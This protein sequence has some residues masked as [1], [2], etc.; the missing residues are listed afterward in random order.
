[1]TDKVA[2]SVAELAKMLGISL[3][4]AYELANSAGFPSIKIGKRTLI[5]LVPF[6]VW[7]NKA[8]EPTGQYSCK[9]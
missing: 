8:T 4:K 2:I 1:M 9:H 3:P 5:P 7:L 6:G